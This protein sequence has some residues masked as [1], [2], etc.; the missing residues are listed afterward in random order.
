LPASATTALRPYD[1]VTFI[2]GQDQVEGTHSVAEPVYLDPRAAVLYGSYQPGSSRVVKGSYSGEVVS[3]TLTVA[4]T[5]GRLRSPAR[6]A[7]T[8]DDGPSATATPQALDLLDQYAV[9]AVFCLIGENA[10]AYP[11]LVKRE[12]ATGHQLCDH[13]QSHPLQLPDFPLARIRS[14]IGVGYASI[15]H[16]GAGAEPRY[17]RAPGGNWSATITSEAHA[18]NLIPLRWTVDPRDWSM[19]GT[20][21]I[22][23]TVLDQLRPDGIVLMHDGGG[24]RSQTVQALAILLDELTAA[25]WT[26]TLPTWVS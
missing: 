7:L 1:V 17:F 4:P 5:V 10:L 16:A 24:D 22:I 19:P 26:I 2:A 20:Q 9:K 12:A 18:M 6:F 14:E 11:R 15:V 13:T 3:S 8:I 23:T 21:S 25:G